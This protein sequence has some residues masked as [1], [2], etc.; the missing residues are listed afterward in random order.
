MDVGC[1][2]DLNFFKAILKRFPRVGALVGID[3]D[4]SVSQTAHV[5]NKRIWC[6]VANIV[7]RETLTVFEGMMD[8]VISTN[9]VNK[10]PKKKLM[11]ENVYRLL[12]PG[13]E[14]AFFFIL[15]SCYHTFLM[16]LLKI[17]KFKEI[18]KGRHNPNMY[19]KHRRE[20]YYKKMLEEVGFHYVI[21]LE[22]E[23]IYPH[24]SEEDWK[25]ELYEGY[26]N[27]FEVSPESV[28]EIKEEAF[29]IYVKTIGRYEG[30]PYYRVLL[31]SLFGQKEV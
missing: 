20:Q 16:A 12:R 14:A 4:P 6:Y 10:I 27:M 17:P 15:D 29:Q 2:R 24:P 22:E 28:D 1:G 11:F 19:P 23:K 31:L 21:S 26:K 30:E 25:D 7:K 18:F 5:K 8:K 13:G 3:K 9:T